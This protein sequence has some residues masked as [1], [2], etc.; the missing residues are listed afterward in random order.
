MKQIS[1]TYHDY[2]YFIPRLAD[3]PGGQEWQCRNRRTALFAN[4]TG[5]S[6]VKTQTKLVGADIE[7]IKRHIHLDHVSAWRSISGALFV[8][9]EPYH[10]SSKQIQGLQQA[11]YDVRIIPINLAPYCGRFNPAKGSQPWTTSL[12]ITHRKN[13]GEIGRIYQ[14]LLKAVRTAPAWNT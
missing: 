2:P 14:D 4:T 12:L 13:A 1:S 5:L 3:S 10:Y 7:M 11:G 8:L 9:I 6:A